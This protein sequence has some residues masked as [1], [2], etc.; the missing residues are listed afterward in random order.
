MF[1]LGDK[2]VIGYD[3]STEY[4]QISFWSSADEAPTTVSLTSGSEDYNIPAC[5]FK[6]SDVNQWY[7]GKEAINFSEVEQGQ[8]I[9]NLWEMALIGEQV[10]VVDSEF[11]PVALL[12]LFIKRSLSLIKNIKMEKIAGIMFTVPG[13]TKRAIEVLEQVVEVLDLANVRV[14][15]IGREESIY[16]YVIHQQ[17]ELWNHDVWIYD[18]SE[19]YI[20]GYRFYINRQATPCV[21]FVEK[22]ETDITKDT[23]NKDERFL[24][25]VKSNMEMG[26]S[27]LAYMIGP[28]FDEPWCK[29]SLREICR[30][31]R[32]FKGNNLYS[33]GACFAMRTKMVDVD[34]DRSLIFLGK[35]KLKVNV[36]MQIRKAGGESY[37]AILDG[38]VNW[39]DSKKEFDV[40]IDEG[41]SLEIT[42]TP[43]DGKN[44][45]SVEVILEGLTS[46]EPKT[47][48]IHL[49]FFMESEDSLRLCATDMG[50]GDFCPTTYQL[51]SKQIKL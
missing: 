50:F 9:K 12:A 2:Y 41:N 44:A 16:Y 15:F 10:K 46:R 26:I 34:M 20:N 30:N 24:E 36:G 37:F 6:R 3:I 38:G 47:S 39:Y 42:I 29:D 18:F 35:D 19:K 23:V 8:L 33:K 31:R 14:S 48:R 5:L 11:D 32:A 21:A 28:G 13:L 51:F 43:L 25:T 7:F 4:S 1:S 49:K 27:S 22:Y 45:R 40:I 17:R